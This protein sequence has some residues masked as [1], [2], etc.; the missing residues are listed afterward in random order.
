MYIGIMNAN[1]LYDEIK[2]Q[3]D[4]FFEVKASFVPGGQVSEDYVFDT[5]ESRG[6]VQVLSG[7]E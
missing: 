2:T 5:T 4:S 6:G 7:A 3:M 1:K